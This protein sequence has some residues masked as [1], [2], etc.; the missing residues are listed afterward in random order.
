MRCYMS[1]VSPKRLVLTALAGRAPAGACLGAGSRAG[2]AN[3]SS[4]RSG[5]LGHRTSACRPM[6][7]S[8]C[9][10]RFCWTGRPD[11]QGR[12]PQPSRRAI[13]L[14]WMDSARRSAPRAGLDGTVPGD[15]AEPADQRREASAPSVSSCC[16]TEDAVVG[17][18][19]P[20]S[21]R[22][23]LLVAAGA[24]GATALTSCANAAESP[25]VSPK[26][27]SIPRR[28][29]HLVLLG[30]HGGPQT[31]R[32]RAGVSSALV[33]DGAVYLID[34]GR[35]AVSQYVEAGL[36]W[37]DLQSVFVTHMHA[38][39]VTE[40]FQVFLLGGFQPPKQGDSL[41]GPIPVYGPGAAGGLPSPFGGGH[42]QTTHQDDPTP[43]LSKFF[44]YANAAFAYSTNVFMRDSGTRNLRDLAD[45]HEI[46]LPVKASFEQTAPSMRPF[47][48]MEDD[49]VRVT[50]VLV[51]HGPVFPAFAYRFDT[52]YGSVTFSGDTT[53]HSN[54]TSLA[55]RSDVLVHEAINV[56]GWAGS[57]AVAD[58]LLKSHVEVQHVGAVAQRADVER[59]VLSHI[60]DMAREPLS[61]SKWK[62]WAQRGYGGKVLVGSDMDVISLR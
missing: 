18:S 51:P 8:E 19:R 25:A 32:D 59:L 16:S 33:V 38:D 53:Y 61:A 52:D 15:R 58:H 54:L 43:G 47:T 4:S 22:R 27:S 21:S 31:S 60:G 23:R 30:T 36:A 7:R 28:G 50:A 35:K 62:R 12:E 45:V 13:M 55:H 29:A 9:A 41:A 42:S 56:Q 11:S 46:K 5:P 48:V 20:G 44:D 3:D 24:L 37:A 26:P 14:R 2:N 49:R 17:S 40:L 39:H 10:V 6:E 34:V 57:P 1:L